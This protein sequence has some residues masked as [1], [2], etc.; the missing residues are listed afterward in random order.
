MS[1][2][3]QDVCRRGPHVRCFLLTL[4]IL[5]SHFEFVVHHSAGLVSKVLADKESLIKA[6]LDTAVLI[7][8]KSP[9]AV[10]GTKHHLNYSR[11]H[12]I[13]ES[14]DYIVTWNAAHLQSEDLRIAAVA[15]MDKNGPAPV[16]PKL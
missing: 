5:F 12:S 1:H 7:A 13:A 15:A 16:F 6:A 14:L 8:S 3:A 2:G 11:D 9:V 10:Q 4:L